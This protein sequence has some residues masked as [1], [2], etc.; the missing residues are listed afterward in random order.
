MDELK[1][2][3]LSWKKC[4]LKYKYTAV[5]L[6]AGVF[7]MCL[8]ERSVD[9]IENVSVAQEEE[10]PIDLTAQLE[11]ILSQIRGVG[12][13]QVMLTLDKSETRQLQQDIHTKKDA[14]G[15]EIQSQTVLVSNNSNDIPVEVVRTYP[16]YRG[17]LVVCAGA[18]KASVKLDIV[19]A[20]S[21]LTGLGADQIAVIKMKTN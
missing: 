1:R 13:V 4:A 11:Q 12:E 17:A 8:P 7:L 6:L 9:V 5:I 16:I 2:K 18:D 15:S 10:A 14:Q 19:R 3:V 21:S 20:V